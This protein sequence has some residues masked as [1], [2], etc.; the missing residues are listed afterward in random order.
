[1]RLGALLKARR[2]ALDW[3]LIQAAVCVG[4][5]ASRVMRL[6]SGRAEETEIARALAGL[7]A[8]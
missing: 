1:V 3:S 4:M 5:P 8:M 6:E 2:K 7:E